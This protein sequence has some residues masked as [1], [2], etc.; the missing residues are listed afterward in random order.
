MFLDLKTHHGLTRC[1]KEL[2]PQALRLLF[3]K[4]EG[5]IGIKACL[6]ALFSRKKVR[7]TRGKKRSRV[8]FQKL[9]AKGFELS[10]A[11]I[12]DL[13]AKHELVEVRI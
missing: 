13:Y 2:R 11:E 10:Q 5:K 12:D 3:P 1:P 6:R 7:N 4:T 8:R 9:F